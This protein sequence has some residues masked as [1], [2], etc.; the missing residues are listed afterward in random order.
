MTGRRTRRIAA[1]RE[2]VWALVGDPWHEPR[3]WPRVERVEAVSKRGWTSVLRSKRDNLVR[4]DWVVEVDRRP[5]QRRWAQEL[6]DTP[7]E[8][9]FARN[10]VEVRLEAVE[11]A[12]AVTLELE[13]QLR[14]LGRYAP[15]LFTRGLRRQI[16]AALDGLEA[17]L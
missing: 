10:A 16:D 2:R 11:G 4:V 5:D 3:W 13:Q 7:F 12:T 6:V 9:L 17:A 15:W 1:P 8:R 14:G